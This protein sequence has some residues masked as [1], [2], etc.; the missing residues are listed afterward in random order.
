MSTILIHRTPDPFPFY[1]LYVKIGE[2][3]V[4][5]DLDETRE[6]NLPAGNYTIHAGFRFLYSFQNSFFFISLQAHCL[7]RFIVINNH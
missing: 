2:V 7:L 6:I 4:T 5:L 1:N 3:S